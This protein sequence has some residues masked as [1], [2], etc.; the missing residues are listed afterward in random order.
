MTGAGIAASDGTHIQLSDG[1]STA[2][3]KYLLGQKAAPAA[4]P[5]FGSICSFQVGHVDPFARLFLVRPRMSAR[6]V[7]AAEESAGNQDDPGKDERE[8][9]WAE[10]QTTHLILY[11]TNS[12]P[13]VQVQVPMA[14][15]HFP[16]L[17]SGNFPSS[18]TLMCAA[19]MRLGSI[20]NASYRV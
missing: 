15:R 8:I 10:H 4:E 11:L 13:A 18:Y 16:P 2:A 7:E 3:R 6:K 19:I 17:W 20:A 1:R 14:A 5:W 9:E 12:Q